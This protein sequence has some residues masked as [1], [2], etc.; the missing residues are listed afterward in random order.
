[1]AVGRPE[2]AE[3]YE[4]VKPEEGADERLQVTPESEKGFRD[5]AFETGL[6]G[7]Q[8]TELQQWYLN[9]QTNRLKA[10]DEQVSKEKNEAT[11]LLRS[12]WGVKFDEKTAKAQALVKK[13]GGDKVQ[14]FLDKGEGNNPILVRMLANIADQMS[15]D[16]IGDKGKGELLLSPTEAQTKINA[17]YADKKHAWHDSNNPLHDEAVAEM[18]SL[19]KMLEG[20]K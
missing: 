4:I 15:E 12:E 11:T 10:Y 13:F 6:S 9:E 8:A 5:I 16:A 20:A 14:E 17:I 18:T 3:G 19:Y 2:K 7:K 1:M